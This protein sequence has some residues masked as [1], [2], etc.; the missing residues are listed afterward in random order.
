[1]KNGPG[2]ET[3]NENAN[4]YMVVKTHTKL[5]EDEVEVEESVTEIDKDMKKQVQA[6]RR[7]SRKSITRAVQDKVAVGAV[8]VGNWLMNQK[9]GKGLWKWSD[10]SSY[11]GEFANDKITGY[12]K[13]KI[14]SLV[15]L[16]FFQE[17]THFQTETY[18]RVTFW[19][20]KNMDRENIGS[21]LKLKMRLEVQCVRDNL[22]T[23]L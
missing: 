11:D 20:I 12:G 5:V 19:T 15:F 1:M 14:N 16:I 23:D 17:G 21:P 4:N 3:I 9:H 6:T 13:H 22:E 2:K 18:M 7:L 8:Y 10:G